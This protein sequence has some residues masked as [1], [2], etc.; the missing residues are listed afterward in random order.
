MC[1]AVFSLLEKRLT[2]AQQPTRTLDLRMSMQ[3]E[4][5]RAEIE[6]RLFR[7]ALWIV[8]DFAPESARWAPV[9]VTPARDM[10]PSEPPATSKWSKEKGKT[11]PL[12]QDVAGHR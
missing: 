12:L 9:P 4:F 1:T 11:N 6:G 2:G 8:Q 5:C 10:R 7:K 3:I